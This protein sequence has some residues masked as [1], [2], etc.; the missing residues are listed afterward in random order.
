LPAA[1]KAAAQLKLAPEALL[2]QAAL[3]TGWGKHVMRHADGS[4]S[5]NLFGIKAGGR[6]DGDKVRVA[7]LEYRDGVAMRTR[8]DFRAYD[9]WE[10]S[11]QDYVRFVSGNPRYAEAL[12]AS[13]DAGTYFERLQA[14]GYATDPAYA[15]KINRILDEGPL[16]VA[17]RPGKGA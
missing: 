17:A 12:Q 2:A 11:F 1:E 3:E 5:H 9:S 13:S 8:E 6:W 16:S 10:E 7:T 15:E 4:S 14:A